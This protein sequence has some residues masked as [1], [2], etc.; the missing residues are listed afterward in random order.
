MMPGCPDHP[1]MDFFSPA[2]ACMNLSPWSGN[3][4][5]WTGGFRPSISKALST[6]LVVLEGAEGM[7]KFM[8][9]AAAELT[10]VFDWALSWSA[11]CAGGA[12]EGPNDEGTVP[13]GV[14]GGG[15]VPHIDGEDE[16]AAAAAA[17]GV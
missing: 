15:V 8:A 11:A 14:L 16:G 9:A 17:A 13:N 5:R 2:M 4:P 1:G 6:V 3:C 12:E 10:H 7:P